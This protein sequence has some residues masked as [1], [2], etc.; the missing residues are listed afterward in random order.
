MKECLQMDLSMEL[1]DFN[2]VMVHI[3]METLEMVKNMVK[4]YLMIM[5]IINGFIMNNLEIM[6]KYLY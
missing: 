1:E 6:T 3:F 4:F 5:K 2:I